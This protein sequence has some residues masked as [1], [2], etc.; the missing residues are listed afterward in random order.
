MNNFLGQTIQVYV[1][2]RC[3][4]GC[5]HCK[6]KEQ[7]MPDMTLETFREVVETLEILGVERVEPWANDPTLHPE[8]EE[9]IKILNESQ[10]RYAWLTVGA[11]PSNPAIS[12]IFLEI[13]R[14]VDKEKGG[15]VFSVDFTQDSAEK[16][17]SAG[18]KEK[19][20]YAF[21]AKIFWD[22]SSRFQAEGIPIRINSV[23]SRDNFGEVASIIRRAVEM[24]LAASFCEVQYR[25]PKFINLLQ[26]GLTLKYE[27]EFRQFLI[28]SSLLSSPE[29]EFI[30]KK[31]RE[32]VES[33]RKMGSFN[34]FRGDD[35]TEGEIPREGLEKLI[36]ELLDIKASYPDRFLPNEDLIRGIGGPKIGCL[37]LLKTGR[38]SAIKI[39]TRG[40]MFFCC[41]L[42]DPYTSQ[43]FIS[44]MKNTE[45]RRKF[46]EMIRTN[47]Y[48]WICC[49]FNSCD[50]SVNTVPYSV[51]A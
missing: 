29:T 16:I 22:L 12:Q 11:S 10:L 4:M 32:I 48:I 7:S 42:W 36:L 26:N 17:L 51:K 5:Q 9:M 38:F 45:K 46:L 50:F 47:P 49:F 31:T 35:P 43:Y 41:D 25:Q 2:P 30:I 27:K 28:S 18:S 21:K 24:K 6:S 40:Q 13:M 14:K 34:K 37:D 19:F 39:G 20:A 44:D 15:F 33:H 8:A 23:I 1:T 3:A